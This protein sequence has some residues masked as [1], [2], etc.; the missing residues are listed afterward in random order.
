MYG[1][2]STGICAPCHIKCATCNGSTEFSCLSCKNGEYLNK[3]LNKPNICSTNCS[4]SLA[5]GVE[6]T[7]ACAGSPEN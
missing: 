4:G 2:I 5:C 7:V 1:E 3:D 6:S